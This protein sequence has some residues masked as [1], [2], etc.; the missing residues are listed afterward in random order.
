MKGFIGVG[1]AV[2]AASRVLVL[3]D[4]DQDAGRF[5]QL[6]GYL[7]GSFPGAATMAKAGRAGAL[8]VDGARAYEHLLVLSTNTE[9]KQQELLQFIAAGG[10]VAWTLEPGK[11]V[12]PATRAFCSAVGRLVDEAPPAVADHFNHQDGAANV[13]AQV[14]SQAV[15]PDIGTT[16][17]R[18]VSHRLDRSNPLV[19]PVLTASPSA[20]KGSGAY[21]KDRVLI[22]GL[23]SR[24]GPRV[25]L[26][27]SL[28][29]YQDGTFDRSLVHALLQWTFRRSS[30]QRID[31]LNA[32]ILS[33]EVDY[34]RIRDMFE[35]E[36]CLS[37][38]SGGQ[39]V[40]FLPTDAQVELT[41]M[42]PWIRA[43]LSP[44]PSDAACLS[45]GP[46]QLPDRYGAFSLAFRYQRHGQTHL[47]AKEA[48]TVYPYRYEHTPRF[49]SA[50]LPYYVAWVSQMA[51]CLA[52]VIPVLVYSRVR[53]SQGK[54]KV[55]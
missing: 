17:Y 50:Q 14:A 9:Y 45:T 6:K 31:K 3:L 23:A 25:T 13:K 49:L 16:Y 43:G 52:V 32:R 38:L 10:D 20:T 34:L 54:P 44:S 30:V 47:G 46:I 48:L 24:D 15:L 35:V 18:G 29:M 7:E 42:A 41:M 33:P 21:G 53:A 37:Q 28:Q 55:D 4:G 8:L 40:P 51:S 27:G 22:S 39:W 36:V 11:K 19:F 1:L 26:G 12:S 5:S 2:V